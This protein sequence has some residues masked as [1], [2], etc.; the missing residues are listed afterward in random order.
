M[1]ISMVQKTRFLEN[2]YKLYYSN[3]IKPTDHQ[4]KKAF[5]DYFSVNKP[6]FPLRLNYNHIR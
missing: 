1:N 4:I 3:G 6:G 5:S 2:I